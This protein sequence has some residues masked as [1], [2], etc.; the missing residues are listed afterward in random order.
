MK[1][2][3]RSLISG[4]L[5]CG[6]KRLAELDAHDRKLNKKFDLGEVIIDIDHCA[7]G[8]G[9]GVRAI[10]KCANSNSNPDQESHTIFV[11]LEIG[12]ENSRLSYQFTD[13]RKNSWENNG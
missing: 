10:D 11:A 7:S 1:L 6:E 8:I 9:L 4:A 13:Q 12:L 5:R 3:A 2:R